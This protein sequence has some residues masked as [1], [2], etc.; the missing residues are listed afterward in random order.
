MFKRELLYAIEYHIK[1]REKKNVVLISV[2]N[3]K[4]VLRYIYAKGKLMAC[5]LNGGHEHTV[6]FLSIECVFFFE[7]RVL[8]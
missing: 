3:E 6:K 8:K 5:H 4:F 1:R 2:S 7:K